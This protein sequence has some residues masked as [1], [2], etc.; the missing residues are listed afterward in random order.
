M[1]YQ[2]IFSVNHSEFISM[3]GSLNALNIAIG[4]V[5]ITSSIGTDKV[6]VTDICLEE[7]DMLQLALTHGISVLSKGALPPVLSDLC[8]A[9]GGVA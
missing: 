8:A 4:W 6:T 3:C 9:V 2:Y 1:K 7:A 5:N